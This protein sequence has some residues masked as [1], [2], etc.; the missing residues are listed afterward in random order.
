MSDQPWDG[1]RKQAYI[2]ETPMTYDEYASLPEDGNRYELVDGMLQCMS[3]APIIPHQVIGMKFATLLSS[4]CEQDYLILFAPVDVI[5][6]PADVFQPDLLMIHLSRLSIVSLRA[7]EGAPDLVVEI[8]SPSSVKHDQIT[9]R[10]KYAQYQVP[11]YWIIDPTRKTLEMLLL[12]G[13]EYELAHVYKEDVQIHSERIS[14]V[15]FTMNEVMQR[16]IDLRYM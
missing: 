5:F 10:R 16:L 13:A 15:S 2:R 6:S 14:C 8:L 9:K 4:C 11:E 12:H 7:V 1:R 3:P